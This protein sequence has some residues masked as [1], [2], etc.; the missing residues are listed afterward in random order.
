MQKI[1]LYQILAVTFNCSHRSHLS[2]R[3]KEINFGKN[4]TKNG[5]Q[6]VAS[7]GVF[8]GFLFLFFVGFLICDNP[9]TPDLPYQ[10][11]KATPLYM[12][13]KME[14]QKMHERDGVRESD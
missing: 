8:L 4:K 3:I 13:I 11:A 7:G 9:L 2:L 1:E 5:G 6:V 12:T 10:L 14:N